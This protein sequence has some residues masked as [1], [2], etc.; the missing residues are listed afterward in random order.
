MFC[1]DVDG[2]FT[3]G[4]MIYTEAGDEEK[5]FNTYDGMALELL[6]LAGFVQQKPY[7][8]VIITGEKAK[9]VERR[10]RKLKVNEIH[11]G[12]R[13]KKLLLKSLQTKYHVK[14]EETAVMGDDI[15]DIPM[16]EMAGLRV[17]TANAPLS[18]VASAK[19]NKLLDYQTKLKGGDGAVREFV[20]AFLTALG[21]VGK[22]IAA[23][24][25]SSIKDKLMQ[26]DHEHYQTEVQYHE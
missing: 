20:D 21:L 14:P 2:V 17:L 9:L 26:W 15:Q 12:V 1:F 13:H 6:R 10:F 11:L 18:L 24:N 25:D 16:L 5:V 4:T 19:K 22:V 3:P 8:L 7:I 23:R